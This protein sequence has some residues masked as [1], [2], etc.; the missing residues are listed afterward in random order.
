MRGR[1]ICGRSKEVPVV[2]FHGPV[3]AVRN[4]ALYSRATSH[5]LSIFLKVKRTI[6]TA[7]ER[8]WGARMKAVPNRA[9]CSFLDDLLNQM[10]RS[11]NSFSHDSV[12]RGQLGASTASAEQIDSLSII[13]GP[14]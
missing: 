4:S 12:T 6:Q 3:L 9:Q 1:L 7:R 5:P 8:V 2:R 14:E 13:R 10:Q 11:R